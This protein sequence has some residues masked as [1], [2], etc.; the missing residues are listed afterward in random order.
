VSAQDLARLLSF[1]SPVVSDGLRDIGLPNHTALPGIVPVNRNHA[2][3]G[4]VRT[5]R[6]EIVADDPGDFRPLARFIDAVEPGEILLLAGAEGAIPGS[7]WGEICSAAALA[8]GAAGVVIDGYMRDELALA[9]SGLPLFSR[10][11]LARDSLKR[12]VIAEVD[13]PVSV[14][15]VLVTPGDIALADIDGLTFFHPDRLG[16]LLPVCEEKVEAEARLLETAKAG[17]S[18]YEA[19]TAAGTL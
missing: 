16:E 9:E 13:V 17:G 18:L 4:P 7:L 5:A 11:A 1:G 19:V 10:G 15:G 14:G 3:A 2:C 12:S 8:H 6:F